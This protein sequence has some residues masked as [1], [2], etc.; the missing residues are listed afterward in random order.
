M[1]AEE[2][3]RARLPGVRVV[4]REGSF[5]G[6]NKRTEIMHGRDCI[7]MDIRPRSAWAEAMRWIKVNVPKEAP[8][9]TFT[10][11][12]VDADRSHL[13]TNIGTYEAATIEE[14]KQAAIKQVAEDWQQEPSEISVLGVAAGDIDI[15][16]WD[17]E[18]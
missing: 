3:V 15:L 17:D 4:V 1:K 11:F 5:V 16:E 13:T 14:A 18:A 8:M 9:K 10:I 12:C 2:Y 7:G 6:G